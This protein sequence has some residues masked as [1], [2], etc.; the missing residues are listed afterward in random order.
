MD[1]AYLRGRVRLC[2][3]A[4]LQRNRAE[5]HKLYLLHYADAYAYALAG[6]EAV[7]K[8][9]SP[10]GYAAGAQEWGSQVHICSI[11][12]TSSSQSVTPSSHIIACP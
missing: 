1:A 11:A 9:G 12:K 7:L 5:T 3:G 2:S 6:A 4:A 10:G 8:T